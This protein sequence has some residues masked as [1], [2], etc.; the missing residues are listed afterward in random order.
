[1]RSISK[2]SLLLVM[3]SAVS[4]GA[5]FG[6]VDPN[7]QVRIETLTPPRDTKP[8]LPQTELVTQTRLKPYTTTE[9]VQ[10]ILLRHGLSS[11]V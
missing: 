7:L 5:A 9:K 6:Q 11:S 4:S 8:D 1:M 10:L 3:L 2:V